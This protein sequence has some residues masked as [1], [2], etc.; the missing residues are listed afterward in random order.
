MAARKKTTQ[1][2][3]KA[4]APPSASEVVRQF[5]V[6]LEDIR[7]QNRAF[8]EALDLLRDQMR[9]GFEEVHRRFAQIDRRF[10]QIDARFEQIDRRFEQ[11]DAR[12][13][14]V[15]ARFEQIGG[16]IGRLED[17]VLHNRREIKELRGEVQGKVDRTEVEAIV[18][19]V[20]ASGAH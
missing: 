19:R 4:E 10:E 16:Q 3:P 9:A 18:Q 14:K 20:A 5:T 2:R 17:A 8:G 15:D 6:V 7:A 12:F 13:E 11:I 1:R